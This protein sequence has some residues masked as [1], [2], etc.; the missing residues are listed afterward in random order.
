MDKPR[1]KDSFSW[2][3]RVGFRINYI[4]LHIMGPASLSA[5]AD[6]RRREKREYERRRD[7]HRAWKAQQRGEADPAADA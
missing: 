4:L 2:F 6:P 1:G 5:E 7:L 3:Y